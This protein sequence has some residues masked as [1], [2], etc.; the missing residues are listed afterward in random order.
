MS[1]QQRGYIWENGN[2]QGK[3]KVACQYS[4]LLEECRNHHLRLFFARLFWRIPTNIDNFVEFFEVLD[5]HGH[6][7]IGRNNL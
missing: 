7:V 1:I 6:V 4:L 2:T 5:R 3:L